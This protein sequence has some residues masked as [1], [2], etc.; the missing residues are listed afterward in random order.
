MNKVNYLSRWVRVAIIGDCVPVVRTLVFCFALADLSFFI[1][2]CFSAQNAQAKIWCLSLRFQRGADQNNLS[3]L[4]L[5]TIPPAINGELAPDFSNSASTH[6]SYLY[7]TDD[8]Y[9]DQTRI[10]ALDVPASAD[11]DNDGFEDFYQVDRAVAGSSGSGTFQLSVYGEGAATAKWHRDAGSKDGV[12]MLTL[13]VNAFTKQTYTM[14]FELIEYSGPLTYTPAATDVPGRIRLVQTGNSD[15]AI[16]GA[17]QLA[18]IST[19]RFNALTLRAGDWT[20]AQ[21]QTMSF[22]DGRI[23]RDTRWPTNYF[24][25]VDFTDGDPN[26]SEQDFQTWMLSIDDPNDADQDGVPDLSDDIRVVPPRGPIL[27]L[28]RSATNLVL[29][30]GGETNRVYEI[31]EIAALASTNW[32]TVSSLTLTRDP[33]TVELPLPPSPRFWRVRTQ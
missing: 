6:Y 4:D 32:Q 5:T 10:L 17:V 30:I 8:L 11:T 26:A 29:T 1:P 13:N 3:S 16:A 2:A 27:S 23:S 22:I 18:K 31:Q 33:Q 20:N 25:Y 14:P 9:G 24:G 28:S 12:C 7:L 15:N 19:N 21:S